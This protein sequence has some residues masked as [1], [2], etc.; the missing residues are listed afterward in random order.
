M[1]NIYY[2]AYKDNKNVL[3]VENSRKKCKKDLTFNF[4]KD[5]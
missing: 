5:V 4:I 2:D 3:N 1:T